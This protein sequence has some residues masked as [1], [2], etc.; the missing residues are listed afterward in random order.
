MRIRKALCFLLS[1]MLVMGCMLTSV[2]AVDLTTE[3]VEA[4]FLSSRAIKNIRSSIAAKSVVIVADEL[5]LDKGDK[6]TFTVEYTPSSADIEVG[7]LDEDGNF[8]YVNGSNGSVSG[9]ITAPKAGNY[10]LTIC[11]NSS[12]AITISDT[13]RY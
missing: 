12:T 13:V 10:G 6:V 2:G 3:R 9:K 4:E 7:I 5:P 1:S 11:N 8:T